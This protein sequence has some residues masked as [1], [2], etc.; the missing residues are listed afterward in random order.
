LERL[1]DRIGVTEISRL[2]DKVSNVMDDLMRNPLHGYL[3]LKE[4]K[5][6]ATE[7]FKQHHKTMGY[8]TSKLRDWAAP[9]P[10]RT[11][12]DSFKPS[13]KSD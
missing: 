2:K 5:Y 9:T 3:E 6:R 8:I 4:G 1:S 11:L 13:K 7:R 12:E 10:Q